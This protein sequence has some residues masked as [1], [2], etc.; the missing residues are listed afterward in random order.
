M[1]KEFPESFEDL[2]EKELFRTAVEDFAVDVSKDDK[3]KV[4]LAAL[5]EANITWSDYVEQ[6]PEFK[7]KAPEKPVTVV[8]DTEA[9][10]TDRT[11]E[12]NRG[13][14]I[15]A[16]QMN[17]PKEEVVIITQQELPVNRVEKHL[18]KM[19]RPNPL[20]EIHGHRFTKDN[21]YALVDPETA[22]KILRVDGFVLARPDE[23]AEFY[24]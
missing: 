23:V 1:S 24:A 15:T 6:H 13:G 12:R 18:I 7:P 4:L 16:A 5:V 19:T 3:K 22:N 2:D 9:V 17:E 8:E 11:P 21:P 14:V 10:V 20:F